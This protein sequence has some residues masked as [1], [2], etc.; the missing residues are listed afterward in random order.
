MNF[1]CDIELHH[2]FLILDC[3]SPA[4]LAPKSVADCH[5][6]DAFSQVHN[7]FQCCTEKV[8]IVLCVRKNHRINGYEKT[9]SSIVDDSLN[10]TSLQLIYW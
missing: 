4:L 1:F 10:W 5:S 6:Y 7:N 2:F 3:V 8:G 9:F